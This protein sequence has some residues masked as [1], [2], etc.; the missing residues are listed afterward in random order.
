M[1]DLRHD[2]A[3]QR[4]AAI[5]RPRPSQYTRAIEEIYLPKLK[6]AQ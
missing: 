5:E 6:L 2:M 4:I 1:S 3:R